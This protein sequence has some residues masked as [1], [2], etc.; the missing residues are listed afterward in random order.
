VLG[1][2]TKKIILA[3]LSEECN[4]ESHALTTYHR[5]FQKQGL[6]FDDFAIICAKQDE[7][8]EMEEV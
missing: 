2:Q 1:E 3:H 6:I 5:T 4:T 7:P 8:L